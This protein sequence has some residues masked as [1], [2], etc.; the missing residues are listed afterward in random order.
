MVLDS[1]TERVLSPSSPH[2]PL[3]FETPPPANARWYE[4]DLALAFMK[5]S[6][7]DEHFALFHDLQS[8][9]DSVLTAHPFHFLRAPFIALVYCTL[10]Y[11]GG[12]SYLS[13]QYSD[14]VAALQVLSV[15]AALRFTYC[16]HLELVILL[17]QS[18]T[19]CLIY[20]ARWIYHEC[21]SSKS[22]TLGNEVQD[23]PTVFAETAIILPA[24]RPLSSVAKARIQ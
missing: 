6:T 5:N 14:R 10:W 8:Q 22:R 7:V 24:R 21:I 4:N 19:S 12:P 20:R 18:G 13:L 17:P 9:S 23:P 1:F 16:L 2:H 3:P 15:P 11:H